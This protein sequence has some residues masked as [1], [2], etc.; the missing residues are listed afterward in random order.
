MN[1][2]P[3]NEDMVLGETLRLDKLLDVIFPAKGPTLGSPFP[4]EN[5]WAGNTHGDGPT[6]Y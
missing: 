6:F 5:S 4:A 2:S 3:Y 1:F